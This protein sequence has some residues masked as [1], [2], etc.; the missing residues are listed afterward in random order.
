MHTLIY[1][2]KNC[3]RK[4]RHQFVDC[5]AEATPAPGL[6]LPALNS[7]AAV[8]CTTTPPF[9][10]KKKATQIFRPCC[11][12]FKMSFDRLKFCVKG[13]DHPSHLS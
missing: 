10:S 12:V 6:F 4:C 8:Y 3:S 5:L 1:Y 13:L 2:E 9:F 11:L 7:F